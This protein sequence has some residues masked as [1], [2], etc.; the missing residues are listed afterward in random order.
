[1]V[2]LKWR[3]HNRDANK[4]LAARIIP[5]SITADHGMMPLI[6]RQRIVRNELPLLIRI[7]FGERYIFSPAQGRYRILFA[8]L[9]DTECANSVV[10]LEFHKHDLR[11]ERPETHWANW[12][13]VSL[14]QRHGTPDEIR[15]TQLTKAHLFRNSP[16]LDSCGKKEKP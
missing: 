12:A 10:A 1:M 11:I 6:A 5:G 14:R 4:G 9:F 8:S 2:H 16:R 15:V 3:I 7:Q 13:R